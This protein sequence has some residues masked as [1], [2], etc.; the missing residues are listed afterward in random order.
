MPFYASEYLKKPCLCLKSG[1]ALGTIVNFALQEDYKSIAGLINDRN[2]IIP[3]SSVFKKENDAIVIRS[4]EG[5][6]P[7]EKE[8]P[9]PLGSRAFTTSGKDIGTINDFG[10][11]NRLRVSYYLTEDGTQFRPQKIYRITG[12]LLLVKDC[13]VPSAEKPKPRETLPLKMTGNY[14]FLI[15]KTSHRT[16]L[17]RQNEIIIRKNGVVSPATLEKA[18]LSGKLLELALSCK[19]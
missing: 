19:N 4:A 16:V 6:R 18:N 7:P 8:V 5:I 17:D 12:D 14:K 15:G 1:E 3:L 11:A 2:Q 10:F 13:P 9:A